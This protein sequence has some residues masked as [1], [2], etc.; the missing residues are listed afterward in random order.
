MHVIKGD[1]HQFKS[2]VTGLEVVY[3]II[4][5]KNEKYQWNHSQ[6]ILILFLFDS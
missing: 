4:T 6:K 1:V 5:F 2:L 3:C